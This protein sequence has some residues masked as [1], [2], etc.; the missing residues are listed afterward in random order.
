LLKSAL[1]THETPPTGIP[2][3][4]LGRRP[5]V[6]IVDDDPAV[7]RSCARLLSSWGYDVETFLVGPEA[8]QRAGEKPFD[9]ILSDINIPGMNGLEILRTVRAND[10]DMPVILMTGDP[11]LETARGAIEGG[12]LSYLIKPVSGIQLRE[13]I[14]RAVKVHE[15][16]R[17]ERQILNST[18]VVAKERE[19]LQSRLD[20]GLDGLWMA[21]QP[22]VCWSTKTVI[23]YEGLLRSTE[24]TLPSPM[25]VIRAA[26][27]LGQIHEVG[28][29]MRR[30]VADTMTEFPDVP[31]MFVNLHVLDLEDEDLFD[32]KSPLARFAEKIHLEIT[33]RSALEKVGDV[34]ER[35]A[36]LRSL[37]YKIAIDDL[38]EGYSGLTSFVQLEPEAVKLDMS[39][40]RGIDVVPM[41]K[42][43]V[44]AMST[45][46]RELDSRMIAEGVET[47]AERDAL[48]EVGA[49][50][51]QGF[52]F[53]KPAP[54]F[55][56]PRF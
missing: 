39:L 56:K 31:G 45:L 1:I 27:S 16:A 9:V 19:T 51:F 18:E 48:I 7:G 33:E 22:I 40:I 10:R 5:Q 2:V 24:P 21:F 17:R 34:V 14:A 12:A 23:A 55:P 15:S 8:I 54:A 49:D 42:K 28:R 20:R 50:L 29:R 30:K 6:L 41:K 37:G 35:I 46:C 52:L 13:V 4:A 36:R 47:A 38:G 3:T 32:A 11:G 44:R 53:S 43:L 26:E 25:D